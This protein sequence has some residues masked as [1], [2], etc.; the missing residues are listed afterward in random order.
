MQT[1]K[2]YLF[3]FRSRTE[4]MQLHYALSA[5]AIKSAVVNTPRP[6]GVGCSLSVRVESQSLL[7]AQEILKNHDFSTFL[8]GFYVENNGYNLKT[9]RLL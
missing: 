7:I 8:G 4:A 1:T 5:S 9:L 6:L 3:S 2:Y